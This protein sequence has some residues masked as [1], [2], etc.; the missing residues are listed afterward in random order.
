MYTADDLTGVVNSAWARKEVSEAWNPLDAI[1]VASERV[2]ETAFRAAA[3]H[4]QSRIADVHRW[5]VFR[6]ADYAVRLS[7]DW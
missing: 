6:E 2:K 5:A 1:S 3:A 7:P 4:D